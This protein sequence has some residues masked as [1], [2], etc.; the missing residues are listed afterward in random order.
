[1][2]TGHWPAIV[3]LIEQVSSKNYCR[4]SQT[5]RKFSAELN[6][7]TISN[8]TGQLPAFENIVGNLWERALSRNFLAKTSL[9]CKVRSAN[10][11]LRLVW[12]QNLP[13]LARIF[14]TIWAVLQAVRR[15][16]PRSPTGECSMSIRID[17]SRIRTPNWWAAVHKEEGILKRF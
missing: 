15:R 2:A 7:F 10:A 16:R 4:T 17:K 6:R 1:M 14:A 5:P 8:Q 11:A 13:S 3:R 12:I 9:V